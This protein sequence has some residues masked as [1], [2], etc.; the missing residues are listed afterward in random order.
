MNLKERLEVHA[1]I[2]GSVNMVKDIMFSCSEKLCRP[3]AVII[4]L[5]QINAYYMTMRNTFSLN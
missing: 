5:Q 4:S 1:F 3:F 2:K